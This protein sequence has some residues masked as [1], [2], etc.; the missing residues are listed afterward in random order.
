[1]YDSV[2]QQTLLHGEGPAA[3]RVVAGERS[4]LVVK[5]PHV[6]LQV[7]GGG[8]GAVAVIARAPVHQ[9]RVGVHALMLLQEPGV[10]KSLAAFLT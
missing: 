1:M 5:G 9:P 6:A 10:P 7:E 8:E 3:S 4:Q 2:P